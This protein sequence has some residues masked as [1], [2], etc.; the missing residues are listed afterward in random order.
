[1]SIINGL[2]AQYDLTVIYFL[3]RIIMYKRRVVFVHNMTNKR[4][5]KDSVLDAMYV[6]EE[7]GLGTVEMSDRKQ[8]PIKFMKVRG[9]DVKHNIELRGVIRELGLN[10]DRIVEMLDDQE[11]I[12]LITAK[13]YGIL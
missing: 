11:D 9:D 3:Q 4:Y 10:V 7:N 1:M 13:A 5:D 2:F 6:L 12:E 8:K